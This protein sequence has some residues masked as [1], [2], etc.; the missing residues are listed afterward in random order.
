VP[1]DESEYLREMAHQQ[2]AHPWADRRLT[3]AMAGSL[4]ADQ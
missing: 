4:L 1:P 3:N 2:I